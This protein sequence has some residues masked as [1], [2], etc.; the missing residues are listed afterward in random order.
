[1]CY[2][3]SVE[4]K[5]KEAIREYLKSNEGVQMNFDFGE[6]LYFVSG[7][8]HPK[9]PIIKQASI[10]LSE[11]GLIPSFAFSTQF[12]NEM[13]AKTLNAHSGRIHETRSYKKPILSQRC[14]LVVDGFFDNQDVNGKKFPYYIY[15][16]NGKVFYMGCIYNSWTDKDTGEIRDTFSIV[17][18]D[19]NKLMA[20]IHNL[21]KRMPLILD[22]KDVADWIDPDTPI[23][24]INS[25]MIPFADEEM[26]AHSIS[27]NVNKST[28]NRNVPEIKNEV[29]YPELGAPEQTLF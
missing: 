22:Y 12:A 27:K 11:W 21:K 3:V 15:P 17:T 16:T 14:V 29:K 7:F 23:G 18:T 1:M 8:K 9:L 13:Q 25:L 5:A 28:E 4:K 2:T 26:D 24:R 6:D 20:K 19:A 10:E